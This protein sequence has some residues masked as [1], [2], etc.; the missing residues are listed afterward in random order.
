MDLQTLETLAA[1]WGDC[2][3]LTDRERMRRACRAVQAPFARRYPR[4]RLAYSFKTCCL[5]PLLE[6][7]RAE[8]AWAEITSEREY[9]LAVQA[10]FPEGHMVYNG[11]YKNPAL[12]LRIAAAGGAVNLDSPGEAARL[13][14]ALEPGGPRP[15]VGLRCNFDVDGRVSRFGIPADGTALEDTA[16]LLHRHGLPLRGLHCH[17]KC[18]DF[19]GWVTKAG[20]MTALA[21]RLQPLTPGGRGLDYLDFGGG[22][23]FE[24][25]PDGVLFSGYAGLLAD[26]LR[27]LSPEG[28]AMLLV[29]PGAAVAERA[30]DFAARVVSLN[31]VG[32]TCFATL[33]GTVCDI[34]AVRRRPPGPILHVAGPGTPLPARRTVLAGFTCMED[35]ILCADYPEP[36]AVGDFLLFCHTGAYSSALR[37]DF[38]REA[39]PIV[40]LDGGSLPADR[41]CPARER[42]APAP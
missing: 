6:A 41:A 7:V 31:R 10:G 24:P 17:I 18:R 25:G 30:M 37:P 13:C 40:C 33:A 3:Y 39:P 23:R 36:V 27:S 11:P 15:G 9:A 5:P 35:D 38:I 42:S 32:D 1:R 22:L 28:T 19:P 34:S 16:A 26:T 8:G 29:E 21:R 4:F 20:R 14:A 2:F 12:A